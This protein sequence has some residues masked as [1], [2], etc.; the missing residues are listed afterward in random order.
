MSSS[1]RLM[2]VFCGLAIALKRCAR[3]DSGVKRKPGGDHVADRPAR[4]AVENP[5][6]CVARLFRISFYNGVSPETAVGRR[7]NF[8]G[9]WGVADVSPIDLDLGTWG[10][11]DDLN[12]LSGSRG[13]SV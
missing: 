10:L 2:R 4:F 7:F 5:D 12:A 1:L 3:V 8:D 13:V 9:G 6:L 11:R